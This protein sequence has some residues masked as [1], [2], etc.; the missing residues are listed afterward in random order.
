MELAQTLIIPK[1]Q[2]TENMKI[3]RKEEQSVHDL[4]LLRR[5]N[6]ILMGGHI[7]AKCGAESERE[8]IQRLTPL[9]IHPIYSDQ[10]QTLL[11][12]PKVHGDKSL[13]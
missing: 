9:G 12:M 4:V 6:K 13:I 8:T 5:V 7:E 10:I 2:F 3:K 11:W 1:I